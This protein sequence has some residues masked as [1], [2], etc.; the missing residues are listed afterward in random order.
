M[1]RS[2]R[3]RK[4]SLVQAYAERIPRKVLENPDY[5]EATKRVIKKKAGIYVLAKARRRKKKDKLYYVGI[6][7][8]LPRR[9][10]RHL[11][12][13]H[14]GEWNEFTFYWTHP[15]YLRQI[16]SLLIRVARPPGNTQKGS[17]GRRKNVKR[18]LISEIARAAKGIFRF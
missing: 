4:A 7:S 1:K 6:A 9:L 5:R 17:L 16:E 3:R 13:R 11:K 18:K 8:E 14:R 2:R 10:D 15:K 12:D